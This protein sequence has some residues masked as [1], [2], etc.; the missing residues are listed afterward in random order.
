MVQK[1]S[2][3]QYV[4]QISVMLRGSSFTAPGSAPSPSPPPAQ[5][6]AQTKS[7]RAKRLMVYSTVKLTSLLPSDSPAELTAVTRYQ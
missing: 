7:E 2:F 5:A 1:A 6:M 3:W 4:V